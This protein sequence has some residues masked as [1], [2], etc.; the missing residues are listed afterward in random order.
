[1]YKVVVFPLPAWP[2]SH[3]ARCL[4]ETLIGCCMV[5]SVLLVITR[6]THQS[7][8]RDLQR[9]LWNDWFRRLA[10]QEPGDPKAFNKDPL[11]PTCACNTQTEITCI[12]GTIDQVPAI[13][14][15]RT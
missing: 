14:T 13:S 5:G 2:L 7:S 9:Y 3:N 12:S 10:Q 1:M 6:K 15:C 8:G 11:T 4:S